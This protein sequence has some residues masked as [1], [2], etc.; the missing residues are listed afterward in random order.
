LCLYFLT[1]PPPPP[2]PPPQKKKK[3]KKEKKKV[4]LV[5][6]HYPKKERQWLNG[7]IPY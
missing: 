5:F 1:P 6:E 3:K 7:T 2:P 4:N